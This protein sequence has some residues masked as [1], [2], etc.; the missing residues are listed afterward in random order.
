MNDPEARAAD[1]LAGLPR[2]IWDG[3]S[4]PV[5]VEDIADSG[6]GL[7]IHESEELPDAPPGE[8]SGL[9]IVDRKEIWINASEARDWPGR[10]RFTIGHEVGHWVLHRGLGDRVFCRAPEAPDGV[11]IEDEASRFAGA[12]M[13]PP[14]LVRAEWDR[15][16]GDLAVLCERFGASRMAT[17][18]AVFRDVRRPRVAAE[19]D[20][21]YFDDEGYEAWRKDHPDGFVLTD[22]LDVGGARLHA[23]GCSYLSVPLRDRPRTSHPKWCA[24][25]AG[26]LRAAFP[27]VA[28]CR[29]CADRV[30]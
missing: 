15:A 20:S 22:N 10:R 6:F 16:G 9:L 1:T 28:A 3:Q 19:L 27:G 18:R 7:H 11:D 23:A 17:E 12:L 21:F 13:F 29:R 4:L 26:E 30:R 2:F 14:E 5:P 8:F 24:D 25:D